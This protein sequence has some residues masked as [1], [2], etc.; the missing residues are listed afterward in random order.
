MAADPRR[1]EAAFQ[2][3]LAADLIQLI[4]VRIPLRKS[5]RTGYVVLTQS[6]ALAS[7]CRIPKI[8]FDEDFERFETAARAA[9]L[10]LD[11]AVTVDN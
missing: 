10:R 8:F 4:E 6:M 11:V 1:N 2:Q 5:E 7:A 9:G 3:Q